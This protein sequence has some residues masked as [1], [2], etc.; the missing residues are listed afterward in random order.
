M[1]ATHGEGQQKAARS[2]K[3]LKELFCNE[4]YGF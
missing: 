1:S 2:R 3:Y 4:I